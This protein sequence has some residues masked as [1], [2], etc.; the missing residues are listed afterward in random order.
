MELAPL[1]IIILAAIGLAAGSLGGLLGIGGSVILIPALANVFHDKP[2]DNQHLYQAAA[3]VVNLAVALP[4]AL[5]HRKAGAL[6]G[7]LLRSMLPAAIVAIV[8]GVIVSNLFDTRT[9]R[10]L[11][12]IFLFYVVIDSAI[13]LARRKAEHNAENARVN[14]LTGGSVG[15][16][17]GFAAGLLGIGGGGIAVPLTNMVA[18]VPLR[19]AIA[20]SATVMCI[21]AGIGAS[22][23]IA[24]LSQHH[25]SPTDALA[26][27]AVLCPTA[28]VGG[29]L[30]ASLTHKAPVPAIRLVFTAV[31]LVAAL[32]MTGVF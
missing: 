20:V 14:A 11:F 30:G 32:R 6:R 21:T 27:A 9:L 29:H 31:L 15:A 4:A 23:K 26:L 18:R 7:D 25:A 22:I 28:I 8:L 13:S 17:M 16:I 3:M 10:I 2:W 19:Q 1:E 5:K 12:A 24:T